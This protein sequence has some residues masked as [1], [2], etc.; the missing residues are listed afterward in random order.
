MKK[1]PR[2]NSGLLALLLTCVAGLSFAQTTTFSE[3]Y[4]NIDQIKLNIGAGDLAIAKSTTDAVEIMI[5]YD[6]SDLELK[7][8]IK[9]GALKIEEKT[10]KNQEWGRTSW[11]IKIPDGKKMEINVG[12]GD[13][14]MEG[15]NASMEANIGA[16]S[17][18]L[19]QVGGEIRL[20]TG[21]GK[22][23]VED[24]A[25]TFDVNSG[26][27]NIH[28]KKMRGAITANT[29]TGNVVAE[30]ISVTGKSS[31][32]SGTGKVNMS[33]GNPVQADLG[34]NSGTN[35]SSLDFNGFDFDG[36]LTI[37]CDKRQ[38]KIKAPFD[39]SQ[40]EVDQDDRSETLKKVKRFGDSEVEIQI[41]SGTGTASVD[42]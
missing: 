17:F 36:I 6:R 29:G 15:I 19:Q 41:G 39:F 40:E 14:A 34:I 31:M 3:S 13:V 28:L 35:D 38:G 20:N 10:L 9:N 33:L 37:V 12:A 16:G 30:A 21:T 24:S 4:D 18:A 11:T 22:I 5:E 7:V 42:Q 25:G 32:N 23:Q 27:G 26:T 1:S 8:E 2:F